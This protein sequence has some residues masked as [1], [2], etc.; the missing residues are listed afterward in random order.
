[1]YS[2][3]R[4]YLSKV[5]VVDFDGLCSADMYP[6]EAKEN[7]KYLLYYMLSDEF[8]EQATTAGSRTVLP[9]INQKELLRIP[10]LPEQEETVHI[11]D[12]LLARE[13]LVRDTAK[14]LLEQIELLKKS[15]LAKAFRG[16]LC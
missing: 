8:F 1:M 16:E 7:T 5:V 15:I 3:I 2:K 10:S 4:P 9:K 11:L 14:G 13:Q 12:S 6:I